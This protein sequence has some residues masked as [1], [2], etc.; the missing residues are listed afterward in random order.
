MLGVLRQR[1]DE[2]DEAIRGAAQHWEMDRMAATDRAVL[3]IA[4]A[5]LIT[6]PGTPVRVVLNEAIEIARRYGGEESGRFVN[7]VLDRAAR[8]LRPGEV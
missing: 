5:E 3:R 4:I 8:A 1:P 6:R 2:V 7:G